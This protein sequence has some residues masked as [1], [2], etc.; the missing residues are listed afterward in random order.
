[1]SRIHAR[2]A[3]GTQRLASPLTVAFRI[4]NLAYGPR[5]PAKALCAFDPPKLSASGTPRNCNTSETAMC[6]LPQIVGQEHRDRILTEG[7]QVARD[8]FAVFP[9]L[10][11]ET[12]DPP[13]LLGVVDVRLQ[14]L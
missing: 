9:K 11:A 3:A 12:G 13:S 7:L 1:M 10:Q 8:L 14:R 5:G 6:I 2:K 4:A